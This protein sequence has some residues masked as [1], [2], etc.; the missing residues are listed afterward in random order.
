MTYDSE[1]AADSPWF[2]G[3]TDEASGSLLDS[4][5]SSRTATLPGG[6]PTYAQTGPG[7]AADAQA[8]PDS[9][10]GTEYYALTSASPGATATWTLECWV[11]LTATPTNPTGLTSIAYGYGNTS[12]RPLQ[13]YVDTDGK[14][15][16]WGGQTATAAWATPVAASSALSLNT[17]HHVV[18]KTTSS[19]QTLR[20]DKTQVGTGTF[21]TSMTTT[22]LVFVHGGGA[23]Q[24]GADLTNSSAATLSKP[25]VYLSTLTDARIDAH[26]DAMITSGATG[27]L[28]T[29]LA[30][31]TMAGAGTEE[32]TGTLASTLDDATLAA[33]GAETITGTAAATLDD[34][35]LVGAGAETFTGTL[36]TTLDDSTLAGA[37]TVGT[38]PITGTLAATLDDTTLAAA[39]TET[40]S[41]SLAATLD[42]ATL[43]SSAT[44]TFTGVLVVTLDDTGMAATGA[45]TISG[46]AAPTL[47]DALLTASA[48]ETLTG[49]L[50]ATLAD[51]TLVAAGSVAGSYPVVLTPPERTSTVPATSHTSIVAADAYVSAVPVRPTTSTVPADPWTDTVPVNASLEAVR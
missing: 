5:G 49:L 31:T 32:F 44:E 46:T 7:G 29:T 27:T 8:W 35:A 3:K 14:V 37:G 17:W 4:S 26:Y 13:L 45:E 47:D 15:K 19:T 2:Y 48:T 1:I 30:D 42:D 21:T 23:Q 39:G 40:I 24:G 20:V 25:A 6:S 16:L 36:A 33:S 43:A 51:T 41:G 10:G 28:A 11:Y 18:A 50:A 22:D 34:T 38:V 9:S 12:K